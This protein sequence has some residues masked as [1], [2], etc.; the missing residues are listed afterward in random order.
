MRIAGRIKEVVMNTIMRNLKSVIARSEAPHFLEKV[1]GE[2]TKK[3]QRGS[4]PLRTCHSHESGNL[5][6]WIPVCTGM[7]K[8][9]WGMTIALALCLAVLLVPVTCLAPFGIEIV[10]TGSPDKVIATMGVK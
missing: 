9:L 3:S 8:R 10:A 6:E 7:T 5:K 1:L 2:A 4:P